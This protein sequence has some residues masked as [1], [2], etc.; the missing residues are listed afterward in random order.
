MTDGVV[1]STAAIRQLVDPE[2]KATKEIHS[3]INY[4]VKSGILETYGRGVY[5]R[6]GRAYTPRNPLP[7]GNYPSRKLA[8]LDIM[9]V[10][11]EVGTNDMY[12]LVKDIEHEREPNASEVQLK[13]RISAQLANLEAAGKLIRVRPGIYTMNKSLA[14]H[15]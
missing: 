15:Q 2:N 11:Q 3:S 9:P 5:R 13:S 7:Y 8:L 1:R 12:D 6:T 4:M 10:D 14:A